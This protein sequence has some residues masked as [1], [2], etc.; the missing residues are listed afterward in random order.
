MVR[1]KN[2]QTRQSHDGEISFDPTFH[3]IGDLQIRSDDDEAS[4][5][6]AVVIGDETIELRLPWSLINFVDPTKN[7]VM[8]DDPDE[9]GRQTMDSEGIA[10]TVSYGSDEVASTSRVSLPTWDVAPETTER[11][12]EGAQSFANALDEMP[13]WAD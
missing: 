4:S 2:S 1:W 3:D 9:P 8:H 13:Y 7:Q 12:K 5:L 11:I 6:D 10:L